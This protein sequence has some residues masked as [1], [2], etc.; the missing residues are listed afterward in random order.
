MWL[1]QSNVPKFTDQ[2][3][4]T[5][6]SEYLKLNKSHV[7]SIDRLILNPRDIIQCVA[8]VSVYG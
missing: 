1:T 8:L 6:I 5:L 4:L 7:V 2:C 3:W